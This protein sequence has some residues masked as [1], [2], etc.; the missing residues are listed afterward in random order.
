MLCRSDYRRGHARLTCSDLQWLLTCKATSC[1]SAWS[2]LEATA[3]RAFVSA[4][5]CTVPGHL[6]DRQDSQEATLNEELLP[7]ALGKYP[8]LQ[9]SC[10]PIPNTQ[11][12]ARRDIGEQS[13]GA[14]AF[15]RHVASPLVYLQQQ[16]APPTSLD[17]HHPTFR[18]QRQQARALP[19]E[20]LRLP[21]QHA[22]YGRVRIY[23]AQRPLIFF[24][25]AYPV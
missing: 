6:P 3:L 9:D 14:E 20:F 25:H 21:N 8:R 2:L 18:Q 11:V 22:R 19:L 7:Q 16:D 1:N 17:L 23:F 10:R 12:G 5:S 15:L 4:G 24:L 13:A